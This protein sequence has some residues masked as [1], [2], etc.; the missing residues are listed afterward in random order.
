MWLLSQDSNTEMMWASVSKER[1][2]TEKGCG[3]RGQQQTVD[4]VPAAVPG[5]LNPMPPAHV[6]S[7]VGR[8]L[9]VNPCST[10]WWGCQLGQGACFLQVSILVCNVKT[11]LD[12]FRRIIF[13][14]KGICEWTQHLA[15]CSSSS[16]SLMKAGDRPS[17]H[18]H[19]ILHASSFL[20]VISFSLSLISFSGGKGI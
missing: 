14:S 4:I 12:S 2:V 9:D 7:R 16:E 11:I 17:H 3:T 10:I 15:R 5:T 20:S 6:T 1:V 8:C 13:R 18:R 19:L